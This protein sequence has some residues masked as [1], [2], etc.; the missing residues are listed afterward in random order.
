VRQLIESMV[1]MISVRARTSVGWGKPTYG[2][3]TVG[4]QPG[5]ST[6]IFIIIHVMEIT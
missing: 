4:P 6:R 3:I 5:E 2:N 1:Y